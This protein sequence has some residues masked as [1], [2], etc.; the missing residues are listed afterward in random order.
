MSVY[1]T[2]IKQNHWKYKNLNINVL[3]NI[4]FMFYYEMYL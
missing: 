3:K 4:K 1:N 2:Q